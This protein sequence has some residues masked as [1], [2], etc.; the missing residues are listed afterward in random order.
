MLRGRNLM[1]NGSI[2]F[3]TV[4]DGDLAVDWEVI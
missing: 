1:F 2:L 3:V 4:W